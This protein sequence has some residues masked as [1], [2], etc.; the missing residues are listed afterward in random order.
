MALDVPAD[1]D[2]RNAVGLA[3]AIAGATRQNAAIMTT[4]C[5]VTKHPERFD[6]RSIQL[7]AAIS[8]GIEDSPTVLVDRSC[9]AV[10]AVLWPKKAPRQHAKEYRKLRRCVKREQAATATV[11]GRFARIIVHFG[12]GA[13]LDSGLDLETVLDVAPVR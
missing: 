4:L 7:R 8:P 3:V 11:I 5:E 12:N 13:T 6:G 1:A 10:V 2:A 9:S